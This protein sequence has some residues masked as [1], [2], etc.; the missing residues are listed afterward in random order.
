MRVFLSLSEASAMTARFREHR[1][2]ILKEQY[3]GQDLLPLCETFAKAD[4]E[5]LLHRSGCEK[6]RCYCGMDEENK[7]HFLLV[8]VNA[9]NEDILSPDGTAIGEGDD[10]PVLEKGV[11]CPPDCPVPSPLNS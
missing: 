8:G 11:R 9:A 4:V 2:S 1:E 5:T 7:L 6:L 10:G 3:Q